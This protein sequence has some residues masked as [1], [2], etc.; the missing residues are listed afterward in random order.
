MEK[1]IA[2]ITLAVGAIALAAI[3]GLL[4]AFPL[5]WSWNYTIPCIFGLHTINWGQAW[6]LNFIAGILIKSK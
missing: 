2:G 4:V 3:F 6:C 1:V 5:M